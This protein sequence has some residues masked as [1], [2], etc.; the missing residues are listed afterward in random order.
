MKFI[1][2]VLASFICSTSFSQV[3]T[4]FYD[5]DYKG[6]LLKDSCDYWRVADYENKVFV[7]YYN[8]GEVKA[9]G[10]FS[11]IDRQSD[12]DSKFEGTYFEFY[13]TGVLEGYCDFKDGAYNR[14][15][16]N[17]RVIDFYE[18]SSDQLES[19]LKNEREVDM[20]DDIDLDFELNINIDDLF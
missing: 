7:D 5:K 4:L 17:A 9:K 2:F 1:L 11:Y 3:D 8:T 16:T 20:D 18:D 15:Q 13:K 14:H 19:I 6:V 12:L 10:Q